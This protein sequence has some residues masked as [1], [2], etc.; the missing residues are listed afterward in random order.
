MKTFTIHVFDK[1]S[2]VVVSNSFTFEKDAK[3]LANDVNDF[4]KSIPFRSYYYEIECQ[5]AISEKRKQILDN[6][7]LEY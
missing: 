2:P 7:G 6:L 3:E 4:L 1:K 5:E